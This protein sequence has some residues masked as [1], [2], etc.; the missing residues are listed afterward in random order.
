M[1]VFLGVHIFQNR[2]VWGK[3]TLWRRLRYRLHFELR[4][5]WYRSNTFLL[6][7]PIWRKGL[8]VLLLLLLFCLFAWFRGI[9]ISLQN[10]VPGFYYLRKTE[11]LPVCGRAGYMTHKKLPKSQFC[12]SMTTYYTSLPSPPGDFQPRGKWPQNLP[13]FLSGF[14]KAHGK[15][16]VWDEGKLTIHFLQ[17]LLK[18]RLCMSLVAG[19]YSPAKCWAPSA[20]CEADGCCEP[21]G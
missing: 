15:H 17:C 13:C 11:L 18:R 20:P 1:L 6:Q 10:Y 21:F 3:I 16:P 8:C 5:A 12:C 2:Q 14:C 4:K 9:Y 19:C 7:F